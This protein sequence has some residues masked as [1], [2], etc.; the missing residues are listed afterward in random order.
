MSDW[1]K[2]AFSEFPCNN[3]NKRWPN[4]R[5]PDTEIGDD[6]ALILTQ[7]KQIIAIDEA[8]PSF[9]DKSRLIDLMK[10]MIETLQKELI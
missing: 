8:Q 10:G 4:E 9:Y 7:L 3:C 1:A 2:I 6:C 5:N